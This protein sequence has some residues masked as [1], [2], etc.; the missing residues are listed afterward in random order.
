MKKLLLVSALGSAALALAAP[1][2][3]QLGNWPD[4][5]RPSYVDD[6]RQPYFESRRAAYDNGFREG[7]KEGEKDGR[8]RDT[9]NYQDE[10]AWQRADKGY[11][12]SLGDL[13]RYQ[14]S[15]RAGF[16]AGYQD[17]YQR[18]AP[19]YGWGG[20]GNRNGRAIPR[21][22]RGPYPGYPQQYPGYPTYPSDRGGYRY[23]STGYGYGYNN[24][25]Y[26]NGARD[27]YEKGLEDAR[28]RDSYD[29]LRH[30]WYRSGDHDYRSEYGPKDQ[31]RNVYRD[32]FKEG[33]DRGYREATYR[34]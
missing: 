17:S 34:R 16:A 13:D 33:Y 15:F 7:L 32:G 29:P 27:G 26:A 28:D 14:Q 30:K 31:Y 23:P 22:N 5:N 10:K 18:Y 24:A 11:H 8:K 21:D 12:R 4:L 6:Q 9:F 19:N 3:A 1:A 25:A 2:Q 20:Y